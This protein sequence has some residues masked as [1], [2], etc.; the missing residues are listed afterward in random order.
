M[1]EEKELKKG[2]IKAA[3]A[4]VLA[5]SVTGCTSNVTSNNTL[6]NALSYDDA[7]TELNTFVKKIGPTEVPAR[8]DVD[9]SEASV[10]D[11]LASIDTFDISEE[12]D[13]FFTSF[14]GP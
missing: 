6:N 3:L 8:L 13:V 4:A 14:S 2:F 9:M 10:A 5:L 12:V 7:V 11:S 1:R